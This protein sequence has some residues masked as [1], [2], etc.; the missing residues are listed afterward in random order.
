MFMEKFIKLYINIEIVNCQKL[1]S[2]IYKLENEKK[3]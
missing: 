2:N 3:N 1:Q